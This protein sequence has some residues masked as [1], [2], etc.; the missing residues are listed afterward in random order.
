MRAK[1]LKI[2]ITDAR[3][4]LNRIWLLNSH[5][6]RYSYYVYINTDGRTI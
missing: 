6:E 4:F 5:D 1:A 3:L 2:A